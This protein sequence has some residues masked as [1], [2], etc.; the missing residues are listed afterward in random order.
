M[1]I[2]GRDHY[3]MKIWTNLHDTFPSK[4]LHISLRG[5]GIWLPDNTQHITEWL[6]AK[7]KPTGWSWVASCREKSYRMDSIHTFLA[8]VCVEFKPSQS[9]VERSSQ[10]QCCKNRKHIQHALHVF[11]RGHTSASQFKYFSRKYIAY[12]KLHGF[13]VH[14]YYL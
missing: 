6:L 10:I 11:Y 4:A 5:C 9:S 12:L 8:G 13:S 2:E 7:R 14:L 1:R 3:N